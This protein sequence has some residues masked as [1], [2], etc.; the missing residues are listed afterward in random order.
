MTELLYDTAQASRDANVAYHLI[1]APVWEAQADQ[2]N[3]KPEAY[4]ADGFIHLTVGLDPLLTVAN[5]FYTSDS[6]PYR[7]LVLDMTKIEAEIKYEDP[8]RNYPHI[9]GL[10][11]TDAVIGELGIERDPHGRFVRIESG[12]ANT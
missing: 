6:R 11:N 12:D 4:D 9:Y 2:V 3:Y 10:L 5:M 8:D 1:P 7:V